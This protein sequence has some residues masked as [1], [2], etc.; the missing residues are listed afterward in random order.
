M[1]IYHWGSRT[2]ADYALGVIAVCAQSPQDAR[3]RV[4]AAFDKAYP[5][6]RAGMRESVISDI[7]DQPELSDA[8]FLTG[9]G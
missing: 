7:S 9:S 5:N 8:L 1:T 2:Y 6:P 4:L 3:S